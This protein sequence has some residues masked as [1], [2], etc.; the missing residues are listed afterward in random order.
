MS[1]K[2]YKSPLD[3][4]TAIQIADN[5]VLDQQF[6]KGTPER[7]LA[8]AMKK[9]P[10]PEISLDRKALANHLKNTQSELDW[11]RRMDAVRQK[12]GLDFPDSIADLYIKGNKITGLQT[13]AEGEPYEVDLYNLK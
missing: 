12:F 9:K 5:D 4:A 7:K 8:G 13:E 3:L 1:Q 2:I 10:I 6:G 11:G